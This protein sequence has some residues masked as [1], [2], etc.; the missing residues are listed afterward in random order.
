MKRE[1]KTYVKKFDK[2]QLKKRV[3]F[4]LHWE[5]NTVVPLSIQQMQHYLFERYNLKTI[6][7]LMT[8]II[9][10]SNNIQKP[11]C[12]QC[13]TLYHL[14]DILEIIYILHCWH[15][16]SSLGRN[17]W[18]EIL[19]P[20]E[21]VIIKLDLVTFENLQKWPNKSKGDK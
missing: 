21:S 2:K 16:Q 7:I 9:K 17:A 5:W 20:L 13:L 4:Y 3:T 10:S 11:V 14:Q 15:C 19:C 8:I 1:E 12:F 18:W 6:I